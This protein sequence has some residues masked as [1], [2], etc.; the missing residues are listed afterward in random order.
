MTSCRMCQLDI[1]REVRRKADMDVYVACSTD[2]LTV[3]TNTRDSCLGHLFIIT[4]INGLKLRAKQSLAVT[5]CFRFVF[6]AY[7]YFH[8]IKNSYEFEFNA[9]HMRK[10][11][12]IRH[13]PS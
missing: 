13:V 4:L 6:V 11:I 12:Y 5:W 8:L 1:K 7:N 3:N 2:R 10:V 9:E